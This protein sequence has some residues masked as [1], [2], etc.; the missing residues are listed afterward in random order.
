MNKVSTV[1]TDFHNPVMLRES[2]EG[3]AIKPEGT[4][5]DA[6]FGGG[7]HARA[8]LRHLTTGRLIVF[9]Q[10]KEALANKESLPV[11]AIQANYKYMNKYL[12]L[13]GISS[14]DG[15][16]ADLGVSSHQLNTPERGFTTREEGKLDMRMNKAGDRTARDLVNNYSMEELQQILSKFGEVKNA[17]T[18]ARAIVAA[19]A[20][21]PLETTGQLKAALGKYA[22]RGKENKFFARVFQALRIAVNKELET[23]EVFLQDGVTLLNPGGRFVVIA[24]H[25]LEDRLVKNMFLKGNTE[26][27]IMKDF[28]GNLQSP[29]KP[30]TRKPVTASAEEIAENNRARSAKLRVAEKI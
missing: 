24:Y 28:Y 25:S 23:L 11:T 8:I 21:E 20:M 2:I 3:L 5:V 12:R 19:R 16:L 18:L 13:H 4:Y 27:K 30:V 9:D 1:N 26:G 29:V 10:D 14:V 15:I 7:G 6:T 22:P 17:K